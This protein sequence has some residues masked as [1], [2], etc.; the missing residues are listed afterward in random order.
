MANNPDYSR[1]RSFLLPSV[2]GNN[3][4]A[5][6]NS[7]AV[8]TQYLLDQTEAVN[9][10]LF[11]TTASQQYLDLLLNQYGI[12]RDPLVGI[13]DDVFRQV[14]LQIKNKKQ[15]GTLINALLDA[16]F[17]DPFCK[18]YSSASQIEPYNLT[19]GDTLVLSFDGGSPVTITF[20]A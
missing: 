6:L 19:D 12:S 16:V 4:D 9:A 13:S 10:N 1:L 15:I 5:V 2:K 8:G 20:S 7:L 11:I 3:V 17:G 14:G 18:A